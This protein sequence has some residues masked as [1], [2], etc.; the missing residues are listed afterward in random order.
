MHA[1]KL[2]K[3]LCV[4]LCPASSR[5]S[6]QP[7]K[8]PCNC[9]STQWC[10]TI[11]PAVLAAHVLPWPSLLIDLGSL[12]ARAFC[13]Y[14]H[15]NSQCAAGVVGSVT[16]A[17]GGTANNVANAAGSMVGT[18]EQSVGHGISAGSDAAGH[19]I[20]AGTG[21]INGL[22]GR[23]LLQGTHECRPPCVLSTAY[24]HTHLCK[25]NIVVKVQEMHMQQDRCRV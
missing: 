1:I 13:P 4:F 23:R 12:A 24:A 10:S 3:T 16:D 14:S 8:S 25:H 5:R 2:D 22:I 18:A 9:Y 21:V 7:G 11:L 6:C 20:M 19:G 15:S 17:A